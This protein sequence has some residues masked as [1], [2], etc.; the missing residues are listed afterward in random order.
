[1]RAA[2]LLLLYFAASGCGRAEPEP[3][4]TTSGYELLAS[5]DDWSQVEP[6]AD[7]FVSDVDQMPAC[8]GPVFF[9]ENDWVEVDTGVCNWVTLQAR[10]RFAV[11]P[12]QALR[13]VVSHYDLSAIAPAEARVEVRFG[14]CKLWQKPV[15][16]PSPAAVYSEEL[17][18]PCALEQGGL[19]LFHLHN[20]GQNNWQLQELSAFR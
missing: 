5:A 4:E 2:G 19:M 14:N 16:I 13:L 6:T 10:A 18:S 20:H 15:A 9:V 8:V 7:P 17:E 11:E 3:A 12:R 1:M